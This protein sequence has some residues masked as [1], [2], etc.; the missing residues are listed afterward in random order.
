MELKVLTYN[1]DGL[2]QSLDLRKLSWWAQPIR[3]VYKLI[4]KT[5]FIYI[6]DNIHKYCY[7]IGDYILNSQADIIAVQ[8]DFNYHNETYYPLIDLYKDT[9]HTGKIDLENIKWFPYPRFKADGL[10][11]FV[12]KD[13]KIF[14]E[15]IVKWDESNGYF[16]H[17]NDLLTTKGFRFYNIMVNGIILDIYNIHMDADFYDS[18]K[19]PDVSK[20]LQAR[21]SQFD[22]LV[23]YIKQRKNNNIH[24]PIIIMGDTNS[25]SKYDWDL[26]N[27]K[28]HLIHELSHEFEFNVNE[29]IPNNFSDCDRIFYINNK[30]SNFK[31]ELKECYFD[32]VTLSD[33]FPLIAKFNI[34][35]I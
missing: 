2:P 1:I 10:N 18:E 3:W 13:I 23:R 25:Y 14:L 30:Y 19:R 8:E 12:K 4:K 5:N 17:A 26:N 11:L 32:T 9:T 21:R 22:Q 35:K 33:H 29:A 6:N 31:L 15:D 34:I 24:N 27:I 28:V 20:D 16:S 7:M